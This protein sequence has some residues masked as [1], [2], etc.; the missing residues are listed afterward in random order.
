ME[1]ATKALLIA[2]SILIAI[3]LIAMGIRLY[4]STVGMSEQHQKEMDSTAIS[5]FNNKFSGILGHEITITESRA[6]IQKIIVSNATNESQKITFNGSLPQDTTGAQ[7]GIYQ[8]HYDKYG[9]IDDISIQ[10]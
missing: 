10:K 2:G 5:I 6:L 1:N 4:N 9:Y 7:K 8:A 3:L